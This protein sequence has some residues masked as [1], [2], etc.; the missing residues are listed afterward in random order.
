M[1]QLPLFLIGYM[2]A[3]KS[4]IGKSL[5]QRL[6]WAFVDMDDAFEEYYNIKVG[7]F[8]EQYGE[9]AFRIKEKRMVEELADCE[10]QKVVYALGGGYPCWEDN[11]DCLLEL[12]TSVYI[13]WHPKHLTQR[14]MLTDLSLRPLLQNKTNKEL[15]S[16]VQ[17][18]MAQREPIYRRANWVVEAP[19]Q[20]FGEENDEQIVDYLY[21]KIQN[22]DNQRDTR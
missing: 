20:D 16:H 17:Q 14:L 12:G 1:I 3:G 22:Y 7:K 4:T 5:A 19:L 9:N 2:G 13:K 21:K 10:I 8:I 18:Q 6:D 11:M 15:L